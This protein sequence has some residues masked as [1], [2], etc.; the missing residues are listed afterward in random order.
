RNSSRYDSSFRST[1]SRTSACPCDAD[2]R[3]FRPIGR[4]A[5]PVLG[6]WRASV[7]R[8]KPRF[9]VPASVD[10]LLDTTTEEEVRT[11]EVG[12]PVRSAPALERYAAGYVLADKYHLT[13]PIARGGM[14]QVWLA[15]NLALDV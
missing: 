10:S 11:L 13:K 14:G 5:S 2:G 4:G 7:I 8:M 9:A 15:R 3:T 1:S 6:A 12:L